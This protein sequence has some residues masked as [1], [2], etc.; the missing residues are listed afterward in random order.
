MTLVF[1]AL[2][3]SVITAGSDSRT[4]RWLL[5]TFVTCGVTSVMWCSISGD[6]RF[7]VLVQFGPLLILVPAL[8]FARDARYLVAVLVFYALAKLAEFY[9]R[10]VFSSLPVSGH[11]A[12]HV[13]AAMATYFIYRWRRAMG[14]DQCNK[15]RA[16]LT[17]K[18][19]ERS[20][21]PLRARGLGVSV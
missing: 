14:A 4:A 15:G 17:E 19:H 1:M 21:F 8:W 11:T 16:R 7:Y 10:A 6:L 2:L 12:K 9:D 5:A 20:H 13:L 18:I 3:V